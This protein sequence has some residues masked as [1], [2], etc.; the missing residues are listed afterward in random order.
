MIWPRQIS[1]FIKEWNRFPRRLR[2]ISHR[3]AGT[4]SCRRGNA[5]QAHVRARGP[6]RASGRS[7]ELFPHDE[8]IHEPSHRIDTG[9]TFTDV[10][11]IDEKTGEQLAI[12]TPS[13]P[14]D[15]S[16]V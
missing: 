8:S 14:D 3:P 7:V 9:G 5:R 10:I 4:G 15:P 2:T 13:T 16:R 6:A 1:L 11:A 12:K